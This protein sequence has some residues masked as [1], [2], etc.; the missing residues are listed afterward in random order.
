MSRVVE[1]KMMMND[2]KGELTSNSMSWC[3][4]LFLEHQRRVNF[5]LDKKNMIRLKS[6]VNA[7]DELLRNSLCIIL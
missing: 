6:Y 3:F 1:G 5:F 4:N 7:R 2:D